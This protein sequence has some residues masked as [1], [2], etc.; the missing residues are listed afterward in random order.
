MNTLPQEEVSKIVTI[1]EK[2]FSPDNIDVGYVGALEILVEQRDGL[3]KTIIKERVATLKNIHVLEAFQEE[4]PIFDGVDHTSII[5][6]LISG[7]RINNSEK[8]S[9]P[10]ATT[11]G[12]WMKISQDN[13]EEMEAILNLENGR[14]EDMTAPVGMLNTLKG[15]VAMKNNYL[16]ALLE[17][18]R[19]ITSVKIARQ[20]LDDLRKEV[21]CFRSES[22]GYII[23]ELIK[24]FKR[25]MGSAV[26]EEGIDYIKP[27]H[28]VGDDNK[29]KSGT[30]P[31]TN[32]EGFD[33]SAST[34][35]ATI[36]DLVKNSADTNSFYKPCLNYLEKMEE[37][38]SSYIK[39]CDLLS[40]RLEEEDF[41]LSGNPCV[42]LDMA[43]LE[44]RRYRAADIISL[45][46]LTG[47]MVEYGFSGLDLA[48]L[49]ELLKKEKASHLEHLNYPETLKH[50]IKERNAAV[51][52][53]KQPTYSS[54]E[55]A[56]L[57][58]IIDK[59]AIRRN[60][61][62]GTIKTFNRIV[63]SEHAWRHRVGECVLTIKSLAK[64][65][66]TYKS[67]CHNLMGFI[68]D[69]PSI[70]E[71]ELFGKYLEGAVKGDE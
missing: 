42:T 54:K 39:M 13:I 36:L 40:Q 61:H 69:N 43:L 71:S 25:E 59:E 9:D 34:S 64:E 30:P 38:K 37:S 57:V 22:Y 15:L 7:F 3:E 16:A 53:A 45:E 4:F 63:G 48:I 60:H 14:Y 23:K 6:T 28:R 50:I 17:E 32:T 10:E 35:K 20:D 19:K 62:C 29:T 41:G 47:V 31:K 58:D 65:I 26:I 27:P 46:A 52:N 24:S 56:K 18:R 66:Q 68:K 8:V 2:E 21:L 5:R 12:V 11:K 33:Y 49:L 70:V 55:I 1:L 67:L 44:L 51:L